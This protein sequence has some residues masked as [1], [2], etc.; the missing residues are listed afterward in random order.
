M[1]KHHSSKH[2]CCFQHPTDSH[3][4]SFER[5]SSVSSASPGPHTPNSYITKHFEFLKQE[6]GH[7]AMEDEAGKTND[8]FEVTVHDQIPPR[9]IASIPP[10][11]DRG[12]KPRYVTHNSSKKNGSRYGKST[13]N[14]SKG[15]SNSSKGDSKNNGLEAVWTTDVPARALPVRWNAAMVNT[16]QQSGKCGRKWWLVAAVVLLVLIL[17]GCGAAAA[18]YLLGKCAV[19]RVSI[20]LQYYRPMHITYMMQ[21]FAVFF[22]HEVRQ[23]R[24]FKHTHKIINPPVSPSCHFGMRHR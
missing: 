11:I 12:S 7:E 20:M 22:C 17:G 6:E 16:E 13:S 10:Q 19:P 9:R 4:P 24:N 15:T 21:H 1:S 18:V 14:S 3:W 2:D 23:K 5:P 8:A